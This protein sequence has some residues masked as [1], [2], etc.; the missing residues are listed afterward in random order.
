MVDLKN[1]QSE[2]TK[3]CDVKSN[4]QNLREKKIPETNLIN[5]L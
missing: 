5:V 3:T 4:F 1:L 2:D